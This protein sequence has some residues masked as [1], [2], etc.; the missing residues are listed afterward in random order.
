MQF[1]YVIYCWIVCVRLAVAIFFT[2][3]ATLNGLSKLR[4][5]KLLIIEVYSSSNFSSIPLE[6]LS[7]V[8]FKESNRLKQTEPSEF[9]HKTVAFSEQKP[10]QCFYLKHFS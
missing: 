8:D 3:T 10:F 2:T 1:A 6:F 5:S 4:L 7:Y 9:S